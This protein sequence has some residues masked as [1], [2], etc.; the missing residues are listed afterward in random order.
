MLKLPNSSAHASPALTP[1]TNAGE[2]WGSRECL[3]AVVFR[4]IENIVPVFFSS[5]RMRLETFPSFPL[6]PRN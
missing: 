2:C 1:P 3:A 5:E 6:F 4:I